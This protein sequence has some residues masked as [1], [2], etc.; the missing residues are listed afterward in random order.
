[1]RDKWNKY[2]GGT[3]IWGTV[4]NFVAVVL[5]VIFTPVV[6]IF[7]LVWKFVKD[8]THS[9]YKLVVTLAATSILGYLIAHFIKGGNGGII[10]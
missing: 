1:M 8:I 9:F 4:L 6:W 10:H 5:V 2:D 3:D 7:K